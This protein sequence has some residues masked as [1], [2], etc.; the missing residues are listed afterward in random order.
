MEVHPNKRIGID[1]D[2]PEGTAYIFT[3]EPDFFGWGCYV[4]PA[5]WWRVLHPIKSRR[6]KRVGAL[7]PPDFD[8]SYGGEAV[9]FTI[10][11]DEWSA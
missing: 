6:L 2:A 9:K 7:G 8:R 4:K 3:A 5:L 1:L 10:Q 11:R